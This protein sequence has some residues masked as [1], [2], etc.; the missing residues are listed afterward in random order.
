MTENIKNSDDKKDSST[1]GLGEESR[2]IGNVT[3]SGDDGANKKKT[4]I[5]E[6]REAAAEL[7]EQN[8]LRL[9]ILKKE[10]ELIGRRESLRELG[11]DSFAGRKGEE[12][13]PETNQEYIKR[14]LNQK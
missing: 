5:E 9:E 1:S 11:G 7:R 4:M 8:L 2:S 14:L 12:K 10:E 13:K 6:A 3:S